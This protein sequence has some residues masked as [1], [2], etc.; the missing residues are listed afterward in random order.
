MERENILNAWRVFMAILV[1]LLACFPSFVP[2]RV[3]AREREKVLEKEIFQKI[4]TT[5]R[6][7]EKLTLFDYEGS[8]M[9]K[10]KVP[11]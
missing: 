8:R 11:C 7:W 6:R 5:H 1:F 4:E 2:T 3:G 9:T 10:E